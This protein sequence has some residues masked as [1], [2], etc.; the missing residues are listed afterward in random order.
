MVLNAVT[1]AYGFSGKYIFNH[2]LFTF[3]DAIENSRVLFQA[4]RHARVERLVHIS[5]ANA[6]ETCR[7]E[8]F[9]GKAIVEQVL[10]KSGLS[11]EILR[12][13]VLC[14]KEDILINNIAW[15]LRRRPV[16]GVFGDGKYK[17]QPIYIDDLAALAVAQGRKRENTVIAAIGPET[18][19]YRGLVQSIVKIIGKPRPILPVPPAIGLAAGRLIGRLA[20]D[21]LITRAE[22]EGIMAGLLYLDAPPA[23]RT[24]LKAW[25]AEHT[26]ILG[27]KYASELAQRRDRKSAYADL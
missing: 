13:A 16:F 8:Y 19:T 20:G 17:L 14:G 12:P 18:Y 2:E 4:V 25:A 27:Q 7:P 22:I 15:L 11:H 23:G 21:V 24:P 9:R 10:E 1:G 3:A 6:C 26:D 5:I